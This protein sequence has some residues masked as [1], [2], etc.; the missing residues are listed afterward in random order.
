MKGL[1]LPGE[2][3][4][5]LSLL[6][7]LADLR[8]APGAL[9]FGFLLRGVTLRISLV[10]LGLPFALN[11]VATRDGADNF[12]GLTFNAFNNAL[13]GFFWSAVVLAHMPTLPL[14]CVGRSRTVRTKVWVTRNRFYQTPGRPWATKK[15]GVSPSHLGHQFHV[16]APTLLAIGVPTR[17]DADRASAAA[18]AAAWPRRLLGKPVS[19]TPPGRPRSATALQES[20]GGGAAEAITSSARSN[21]RCSL[22]PAASLAVKAVST[23][24]AISIPGSAAVK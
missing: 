24:S 21:A 11:V 20:A 19:A 8:C 5:L 10:L 23:E 14:R 22:S 3:L 9:G 6:A 13:D 16:S 17:S 7:S 12:L 4:V 2:R 1:G 15:E 18:A